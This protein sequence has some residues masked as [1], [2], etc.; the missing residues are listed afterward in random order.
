MIS[1]STLVASS[2]AHKHSLH[3]FCCDSLNLHHLCPA[4]LFPTF[5][6]PPSSALPPSVSHLPLPHFLPTYLFPTSC[7]T[8]LCPPPSVSRLLLP[9]L[10]P[11]YLC[12]TFC[13]TS[14]PAFLCIQLCGGSEGPRPLWCGSES[15]DGQGEAD[16][17]T[18][19]RILPS[20]G[21]LCDHTGVM[22]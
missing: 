20:C 4:S 9:H 11:T 18:R 10:L 14:C 19:V 12:H 17:W 15:G 1:C 5:L 3:V 2:P 22:S 8:S 7:H 13:P 16:S 6:C 21:V